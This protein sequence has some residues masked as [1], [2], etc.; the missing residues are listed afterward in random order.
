MG[1]Y[2]HDGCVDCKYGFCEMDDLPCR[3]CKGTVLSTSPEHK[4]RLDLWTPCEAEPEND[5]VNHPSHY[6]QGGIECVEAMEA[7]FGAA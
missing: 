1:Y 5:V 7:A 6:T 3:E 2:E 4:I